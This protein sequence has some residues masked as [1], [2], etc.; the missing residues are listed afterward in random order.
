MAITE[1][2]VS[3]HTHAFR[4]A[5]ATEAAHDVMLRGAAALALTGADVIAD[6]AVRE[7]VRGS[8]AG[9]S[10]R[11]PRV[12]RLRRVTFHRPLRAGDRLPLRHG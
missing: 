1:E 10:W 6:P 11:R 4:E 2:G 8:F 9:E 12:A 3:C 7:A 5:A